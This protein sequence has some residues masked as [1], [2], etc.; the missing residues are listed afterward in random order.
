MFA[1]AKPGDVLRLREF[2]DGTAMVF[3][4]PA[5][6]SEVRRKDGGDVPTR[7]LLVSGT[8]ARRGRGATPTS[9]PCPCSSSW[10]TLCVC[11]VRCVRCA[12]V[13]G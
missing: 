8:C 7:N 11:C 10:K 1:K 6:Y 2:E 4:E 12:T 13:C 9:D 5:T 3:T